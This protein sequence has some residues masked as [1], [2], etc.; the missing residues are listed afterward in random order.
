MNSVAIT[1]S[2]TSPTSTGVSAETDLVRQAARGD[3]E[4]FGELYRRHSAP[5]WRLAQAVAT[6]RDSAMATFRE[7]FVRAVRA[8]RAAR[9]SAT[10]FRPHVLASV[11]RAALDQASH[12]AAAP[13]ARRPVAGGPDV[14]L[15]DAAFRSLPERWRAAVWLRD[16][17]NLETERIAGILA[18]SVAVADQLISR[19][20]RGLAGR[21]AQ[22]H[23]EVPEHIG[24]ALR[25]IAMAI[26]ANLPQLT[27]ARWKS[28]GA[29]HAPLFAPITGWLEDRAVRPMSVAAGALIG[30]GLIGLGVVPG[31]STVRGQLGA[32]G[33]GN[34]G[35]VPVRTCLGLACPVGTSP[36]GTPVPVGIG[37]FPLG[38]LNATPAGGVGGA[39]TGT[40]GGGF[41]GGGSNV[42]PGGGI[43]STPSTP[44]N[45]GGGGVPPLPKTPSSPITLPVPLPP[46]PP[47]PPPS[48][49]TTVPLPGGTGSVSVGGSSTLSVNI[50]GL[51]TS[52]NLSSNPPTVT[53]PLGSAAPK[54]SSPPTT[55]PSLGTTLKTTTKS[56]GL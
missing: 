26:P 24:D 37:T 3:S 4:A 15:A 2:A 41:T 22:A 20:R 35:A 9:K 30:L 55:V 25:P 34:V 14:A 45:P 10:A 56:L 47:P 1:A 31:G 27:S 13:V 53:T 32:A 18:V 21:F 38:S 52:A 12:R 48:Q 54:S 17:E 33:N 51:N 19:G 44:V 11:Y 6:D 28:A 43:P 39:A 40:T 36:S 50:L 7:G 46:L 5:A 16:V 23:H 49:P 29:D 8:N 42:G